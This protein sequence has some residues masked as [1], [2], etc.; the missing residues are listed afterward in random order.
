MICT[1]TIKTA[2]D[3]PRLL[4]HVKEKFHN[5]LRLEVY[6]DK[7]EDPDWEDC[8]TCGAEERIRKPSGRMVE[9]TSS[10]ELDRLCALSN[11]SPYLLF[12]SAGDLY[13]RDRATGRA[14]KHDQWGG[15]KHES[16]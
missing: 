8:P 1:K 10:D 6:T 9:A 15:E 3:I 5:E 4:R 14:P 7:V 16:E 2:A 12:W 11:G 13:A